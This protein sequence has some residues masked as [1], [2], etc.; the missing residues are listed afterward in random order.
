MLSTNLAPY[1]VYAPKN[2][3]TNP[4]LPFYI[5]KGTGNRAWVYTIK[6]DNT[7]KGQR[8]KEIIG[9]SYEVVTTKMAD[10]LTK[11]QALKLE[12]EPVTAF[13]TGATGGFPTNSLD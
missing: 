4:V 11:D 12:S 10:G 5:G 2:P 7:R 6:V 3:R 8:I 13:G 9:E 1:Y